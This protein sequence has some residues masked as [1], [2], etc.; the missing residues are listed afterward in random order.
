MF[1]KKLLSLVGLLYIS[2]KIAS[3]SAV[4]TPTYD[5][6]LKIG[7][8]CQPGYYLINKEGNGFIDGEVSTVC[9]GEDA[10]GENYN[11]CK[12]VYCSKNDG[13]TACV[14]QTV[15]GLVTYRL[16]G[17]TILE[18]TGGD[19]KVV[20]ASETSCTTA[21]AGGIITD[22]SKLCINAESGSEK[23]FDYTVEGDQYYYINVAVDSTTVF[24][25]NEKVLVK[26]GKGIAAKTT[27][28]VDQQT[29]YLAN[30]GASQYAVKD[31]GLSIGKNVGLTG[32]TPIYCINGET[33]AIEDRQSNFCSSS[34]PCSQYCT[35]TNGECTKIT[36][37][38][39]FVFERQIECKPNGES[40]EVAACVDGY[41]ILY[42]GTLITTGTAGN[43]P[44]TITVY[45]CESG[46]CSS[47][48]PIGFIANADTRTKGDLPFVK[49]DGVNNCSKLEN[50]DKADNLG[51]ASKAGLLVNSVSVSL[52]ATSKE[53][54]LNAD[55]EYLLDATATSIF[56]KNA[57]ANHFVIIKIEFGSAILYRKSVVEAG[58]G[59]FG[60]FRYKYTD[61][62]LKL[63]GRQASDVCNS[64]KTIIEYMLDKQDGTIAS[65]EDNE[66]YAVNGQAKTWP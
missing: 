30:D 5:S 43:T 40:S 51:V 32:G 65:H 10:G 61:N 53:A 34:I 62:S 52:V 59:V 49:C 33:S 39:Q 18:C 12:L 21:L 60:E 56:N 64:G 16:D 25:S 46:E 38:E 48:S 55:G 63:F 54:Q 23:L 47:S 1:G 26:I 35:F 42:D 57:V 41:Y 13:S 8:E 11:T 37:D 44:T 22:G 17:A 14:S 36:N 3:V 4:C 27:A 2:C 29:N 28:F 7:T 6:G 15:T 66:Y 24:G 20:I 58:G 45:R 9:N 19:C 50:L 31:D